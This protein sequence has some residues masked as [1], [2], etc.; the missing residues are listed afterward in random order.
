[1]LDLHARCSASLPNV[2]H[3]NS[4]TRAVSLWNKLA[5]MGCSTTVLTILQTCTEMLFQYNTVSDHERRVLRTVLLQK[6]SVT[7]M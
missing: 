4:H 1:M 3:V 7:G 2:V 6:G 5:T